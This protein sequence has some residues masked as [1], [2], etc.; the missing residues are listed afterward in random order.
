MEE[1]EDEDKE[2]KETV[3]WEERREQVLLD[4][5][6]GWIFFMKGFEGRAQGGSPGLSLNHEK[7]SSL[8]V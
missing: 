5:L 1:R 8:K 7:A 4:G 6:E 3:R 2:A